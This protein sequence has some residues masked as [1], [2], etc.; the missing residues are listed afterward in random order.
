M[1]NLKRRRI[2]KTRTALLQTNPEK[3]SVTALNDE[4]T[5]MRKAALLFTVFLVT[6]GLVRVMASEVRAKVGTEG[7]DTS[8]TANV[9]SQGRPDSEAGEPTQEPEARFSLV[10]VSSMIKTHRKVA[11]NDQSILSKA[12]GKLL[13][14]DGARGEYVHEQVV[15]VPQAQNLK[16]LTWDA[17]P[18]HGPEGAEIPVSIRIVG[19]LRTKENGWLPDPLLSHLTTV[20][21]PVG[22]CQPLWVTIAIPR[23]TSPGIYTGQ[24]R[25]SVGHMEQT[26]P[27][28]LRVR[29]F[30]IPRTRHLRVANSYEEGVGP[31]L[32]GDRWNDELKWR[33]RQFILDHRLNVHSIYQHDMPMF[34]HMRDESI[35]DLKRL[36]AGGQ[37]MFFVA[38]WRNFSPPWCKMVDGILERAHKA[39]IPDEALWFYGY[40]EAT[41]DLRP[42]MVA[43]AKRIKE[44][45]PRILIMTTAGIYHPSNHRFDDFGSRDELG[46]LIGAWV[47][48]T[49][50]YERFP[51]A[52][53]AARARGQEVWWY[54]ANVPQRPYAN[55]FLDDP[56]IN[57]RLLMGMMAWKYQPDGFLYYALNKLNWSSPSYNKEVIDDGPLC[58]WNPTS[59]GDLCGCGCLF[60]EG[61]D[62]PVSTIRLENLTDGLEDYEYFWVLRMLTDKLGCSAR[63]HTRERVQALQRGR[64]SLSV[65]V[66]V[67]ENLTS[68]TRDPAEVERLRSAVADMI[69]A[70]Q[71]APGD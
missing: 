29:R 4:N 22:F 20:D 15:I 6:C 12:T 64:N 23:A 66:S 24:V 53:A 27:V 65:P 40:D 33:Y 45:Y 54:I 57:A 49:P 44:L 32:Y 21:V 30:E 8:G 69:E 70:L 71:D 51:E 16:G 26:V 31:M 58:R 19:Y 2:V 38:D 28:R 47:P 59:Q 42:E 17:Q 25:I 62:G 11:R 5:T 35:Q 56:A 43:K 13:H 50:S 55:W 41:E 34:R 63:Q 18:L 37:N 1:A 9:M 52:I 14:L 36:W 48:T 7:N 61:I 10:P 67:V 60:Y 46:T 39:G 68:F 3:T